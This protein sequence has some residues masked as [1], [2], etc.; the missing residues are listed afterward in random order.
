ML[1]YITV[2]EPRP[3][4]LPAAASYS[5]VFCEELEATIGFEP[6]HRGFAD[7]PLNHLGTSPGMLFVGSF[8]FFAPGRAFDRPTVAALT[9]RMQRVIT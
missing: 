3:V 6:M 1:P 2:V 8:A 5:A 4:R 7:L 9:L